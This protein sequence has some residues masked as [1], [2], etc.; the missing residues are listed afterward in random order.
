MRLEQGPHAR[1]LGRVA[2]DHGVRVA[3]VHRREGDALDLLWLADD[4]RAEVLFDERAVEH[5]RGHLARADAHGHRARAGPVGEPPRGDAGAVPGHLGARAVR[6]PDRDLDPVVAGGAHLE[7]AV[8]VADR[9][10]YRVRV[11]HVLSDEVDVP[12]RL[13]ARRS[14]PRAPPAVGRRRA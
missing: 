9:A 2:L 12:L 4:H 10:A 3:D 7:D 1:E 14:H 11:Q 6:I 8:G 13:P 5:A